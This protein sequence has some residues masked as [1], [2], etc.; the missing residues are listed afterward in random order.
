MAFRSYRKQVTTGNEGMVGEI[1]IARSDFSPEGNVTVHGEIWKAASNGIIQKGEKVR[2]VAI[3][4]L[5]LKV[6][7]AE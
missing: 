4:G 3:E 1:G 5:V 6:E 2:V 7:K